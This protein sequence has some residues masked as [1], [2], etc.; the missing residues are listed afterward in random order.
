MAATDEEFDLL[1]D[2]DAVIARVSKSSSASDVP[3]VPARRASASTPPIP[4]RALR[5]SAPRPITPP[6]FSTSAGREL[7]DMVDR[8]AFQLSNSR[9]ATSPVF[10]FGTLDLE[11]VEELHPTKA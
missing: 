11:D 9:H 1:G 8:S 5:A 2:I 6:P 4:A 7:V 10:K 3:V